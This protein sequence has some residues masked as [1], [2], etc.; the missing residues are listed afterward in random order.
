MRKRFKVSS[1]LNNSSIKVTQLCLKIGQVKKDSFS[2][3]SFLP[4][5]SLKAEEERGS[6]AAGN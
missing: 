4:N 3:S 1:D 2:F 6:L 5:V